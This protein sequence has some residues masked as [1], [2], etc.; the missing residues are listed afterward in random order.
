MVLSIWKCFHSLGFYLVLFC[1]WV[2]RWGVVRWEGTND[3]FM[4]QR[5][6]AIKHS[7]P[8]QTEVV[9]EKSVLPRRC[10][11]FIDT[12]NHIM[13][14]F[15]YLCGFMDTRAKLMASIYCVI[16]CGLCSL[17][18]NIFPLS[19][20]LLDILIFILNI[21]LFYC[22]H[23]CADTVIANGPTLDQCDCNL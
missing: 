23:F 7:F 6:I 17:C 18:I 22:T 21:F 1:C 20:I 11:D 9:L 4:S 8:S 12:L 2:K 15:L 16:C 5:R 3:I 14:L 19:F 10:F 13:I